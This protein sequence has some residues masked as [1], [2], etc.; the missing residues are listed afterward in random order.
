M[1]PRCTV[2]VPSSKVNA[3]PRCDAIHILGERWR[4]PA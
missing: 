3:V 1:G 2:P 4:L